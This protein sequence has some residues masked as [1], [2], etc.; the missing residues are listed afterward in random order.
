VWVGGL[1][2]QWLERDRR[3]QQ[4]NRRSHA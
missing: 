2:A 4:E 3:E 1:R